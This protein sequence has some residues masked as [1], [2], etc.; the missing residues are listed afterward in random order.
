MPDPNFPQADFPEPGSASAP[1]P[2][3]YD[4]EPADEPAPRRAPGPV[5]V[6]P[7]GPVAVP[8]PSCNYDLRG[9]TEW[10][11]PECGESFTQGSLERDKRARESTVRDTSWFA[12]A[13]MLLIG[14]AASAVFYAI[15]ASEAGASG[16]AWV[17]MF[18]TVNLV[19][20]IGVGSAVYAAF[21][22][23]WLGWA[24][25]IPTT[26]LQ[27]A[28][29]YAVATAAGAL[30][31]LLIPLP[32]IP[33]LIGAVTLIGMLCKV[34]ELEYAEAIAVAFVSWMIKFMAGMFIAAWMMQQV[35]A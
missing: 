18:L 16:V 24:Q 2:D 26:I 8:C 6:V 3:I 22:V 11:C 35:G 28:G 30:A 4:L 31:Q 17:L 21:C 5:A 10:R 1:E 7:R 25:S 13:L 23:F 20:S 19:I 34:L 12:P 9:V 32:I 29:V 33:G 27:V 15:L 14:G